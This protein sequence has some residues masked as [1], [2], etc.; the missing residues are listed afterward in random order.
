MSTFSERLRTSPL[1]GQGPF[2]AIGLTVIA[3]YVG[4]L[5]W[6]MEHTSYDFW[7]GLLLFPLLL[8]ASAP[9]IWR[10]GRD[11]AEPMPALMVVAC[12]S[13]LLASLARYF[14]VF[15]VYGGNA[16]A[17][18][19]YEAGATLARS[20]RAGQISILTLIPH[21]QGTRFLEELTGFF[22][23]FIG[24][25]KIGGFMIFSWL[26]FWGLFLMYRA[27]LVGFPEIRARRYAYVLFFMPSLLFW[28]SSLGKESWLMLALGVTF[29][30]A[31][32]FLGQ[33]R[34]GIPL[35]T[36]GSF[37]SGY[38]RPHV[39][40]VVVVALGIAA[41]FQRAAG[42]NAKVSATKKFIGLVVV[43][44]GISIAVTQAAEFLGTGNK[45]AVTAVTGALDRVSTQTNI[46][47]SSIDS[48]RPN[49]P[50]Q[51]PKAFLSVMFRP[52][53]LEARGAT[54]FLAS[55]ETTALFALFALS[56]RSLKELP[57]WLFKRPYLLFCLIY[58]GI[59]AFAWSSVNNLG[60]LAR[61]R[62]LAWPF[63][64][65]FVALPFPARRPLRRPAVSADAS[66]LAETRRLARS[67]V[68]R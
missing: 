14:V 44:F 52:T 36:L 8:A 54:S 32:R 59:F 38:V 26:G 45:S 11:D 51:Y 60:I 57:V 13:K 18:R 65:A 37:M 56:W 1:T 43:S 42:Q 61:Q 7:A 28:P 19:Y 24:P 29:Y 67:G 62:V 40:A 3:A 9:V 15:Q 47:G 20:F 35:V 41:I 16:D 66:G 27:A 33:L 2:A 5:G 64:F 55:L 58:V 31:A 6:A 34:F 25:T 48:E 12:A 21:T 23:A 53:I 68:Q 63:A 30:G 49:S 4:G 10:T 46:G 22:F 39:T 17:P 50:L